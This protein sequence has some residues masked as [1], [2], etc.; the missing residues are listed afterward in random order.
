MLYANANGYVKVGMKLGNKKGSYKLLAQVDSISSPLH[1]FTGFADASVS[2]L[3]TVSSPS[4]DSVKATLTPIVIKALDT[5]DSTVS[6]VN[7]KFQLVSAPT[8]A[9]AQSI[10]SA[11]TS[12]NSS[13]QAQAVL[14]LGQKS[15]LYT[16]KVSSTDIDSIKYYNIMAIHGKPSLVW[17]RSAAAMTDTIGSTLANFVYAVTDIDTNAV[18]GANVKFNYAS[19]PA[20]SSGDSLIVVAATTDTSG[21]A[22]VKVRLGTAIGNYIVNAADTNL[23]GSARI[24]TA[25]AIHGKPVRINSFAGALTDTIGTK[26]NP[27]GIRIADRASNVISG[28]PIQF[29]N[30]SFS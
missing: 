3:A 28:L 16:V 27:F 22:S 8:G 30:R 25:I 2:L 7:I 21:A 1:I 9:T 20:G 6:D 18:S 12:T 15:G 29:Q 26:L 11:D 23:A 13:G 24:F 19:K 4:S 5:D 10:V 17:Q 14:R